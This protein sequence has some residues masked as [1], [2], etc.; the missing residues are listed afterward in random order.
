MYFSIALPH[1]T[2]EFYWNS[3]KCTPSSGIF[4]IKLLDIY[5]RVGQFSAIG[6]L[7]KNYF[8]YSSRERKKTVF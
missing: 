5:A 2:W 4:G 7:T 6:F 8:K 3:G 1:K